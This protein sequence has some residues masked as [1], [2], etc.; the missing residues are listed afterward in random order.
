MR[1]FA[2]RPGLNLQSFFGGKAS[3]KKSAGQVT[4]IEYVEVKDIYPN[5]GNTGIV[6]FQR[7]GGSLFV[8][9]EV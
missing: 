1:L 6:R 5:M 4:E 9:H 7:G 8:Q 2:V 3:Y